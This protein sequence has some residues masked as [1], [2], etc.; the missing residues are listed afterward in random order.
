VDVKTVRKAEQGRRLDAGTLA[1]LAVALEIDT[2]RVIRGA[3]P[4]SDTQIARRNAVERWQ[5]AWDSRDIEAIMALFHD[6]AELHLPGGPQIP[7]GGTHRGKDEI[8]RAVELAWATAQTV[9]QR[10][11][12]YSLIV[13]DDRVIL[14]G[15]R[16]LRVPGGEAVWLSNIH[17]FT[18]KGDLIVEQHV[19]YDT[20]GFSQALGLPAVHPTRG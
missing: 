18:F 10:P 19:E 11:E 13:S 5:A 17:V 16:G 20:L 4:E 7:F 14:H 9:P 15:V 2:R 6:R 8:R 12:E 1:R 3:S